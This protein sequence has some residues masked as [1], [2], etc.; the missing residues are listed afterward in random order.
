MKITGIFLFSLFIMA[1]S[2]HYLYNPKNPQFINCNNN[3]KNFI[4]KIINKTIEKTIDKTIEV[5]KNIVFIPS[6]NF[7]EPFD[8]ESGEIPLEPKDDFENDSI[9]QSKCIN[10]NIIEYSMII[11]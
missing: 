8:L 10:L 4:T 9:Q 7:N 6:P 11:V 1:N 5:R 2:F 3:F